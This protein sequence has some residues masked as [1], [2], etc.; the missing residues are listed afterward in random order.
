[1]SKRIVLISCV[2]KKL[3]R[4]AKARDLYVSTLFRL[5][6]KYAE[7]MAPDN[8]YILSAKY[9]LVELGQEI[10]PYDL[11]LNNMN[12]SEI[13]RWAENVL[14]QLRKVCSIDETKFIFL[15]G[16]NYRRYLLPE[17]KHYKIPL[18]G[19]RIGEQLKKLK[20]LTA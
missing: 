8:I 11:T 13:K 2:S 20:E 19:L 1:M 10:E 5:N 18:E 3:P 15:A 14:E 16:E 6:L 12:S 17:L 7:K 9:G 4:R